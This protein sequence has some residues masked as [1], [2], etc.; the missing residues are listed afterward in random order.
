[1]RIATKKEIIEALSGIDLVAEMEK[2]FVAYSR[3]LAVVPPV[4]EMILEKGEVHI[5]YG[6]I[7]GDKYYLIKIASGF[8]K[9]QDNG[10]PNGNGMILLFDQETGVPSHILLDEGHLTDLRTAA[11]GA[12]AAKHFA[13][14][15]IVCIGIIG[16]GVQARLQLELLK[17][18][19]SCRDVIA[20][21]RDKAKTIAFRD[22]VRQ[23]DFTC[24]FADSPRELASSS[25]LIVTTTA[26]KIPLLT[27]SDI[28]PGTHITA[29]GSDTPEKQ[30][31]AEDLIRGADL[32]VA[33]SISQS[34][35]RGEIFK[36]NDSDAAS[37][38]EALELGDAIAN[39]RCYQNDGSQIT[40][41]DL[42]GVA[43]QDIKIANAVV[44]KLGEPEE[45]RPEVFRPEGFQVP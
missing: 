10:L 1:M 4:G 7:R 13:P 31:L 9:N 3:G 36:A 28:K 35:L 29:I 38:V 16:T 33:D 44:R 40:I 32:V 18:V 34:K 37:P 2:A 30:E 23:S 25:N 39:D 41:T 12:L 24:D 42:T 14:E 22:D 19:T 15:N 17:E 20:W 43:V 21:G 45:F 5:K 8:Y 6:Y 26:S 27:L 11:A